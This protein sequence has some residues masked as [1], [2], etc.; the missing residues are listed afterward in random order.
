LLIIYLF[1]KAILKNEEGKVRRTKLEVGRKNGGTEVG[2]PR[3]RVK[4]VAEYNK[5]GGDTI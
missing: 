2:R 4:S 5:S 1:F 3:T